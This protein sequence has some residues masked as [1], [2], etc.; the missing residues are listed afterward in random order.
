MYLCLPLCLLIQGVGPIDVSK[1]SYWSLSNLFGKVPANIKKSSNESV[2]SCF[3]FLSLQLTYAINKVQLKMLQITSHTAQQTVT[4]KCK[5]LQLG[6][7]QPKFTG[8]FKKTR[9]A[10]QVLSS[11]CDVSFNKYTEKAWSIIIHC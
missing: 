10:P 5:N 2:K 9:L 4:V 3:I 11:G 8:G 1:E 7:H 6:S